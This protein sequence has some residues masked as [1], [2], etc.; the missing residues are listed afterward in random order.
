M[1]Y[2]KM[3]YISGVIIFVGVIVILVAISW[4]SGAN[5]FFTRDYS[6]YM[7][8]NEVSG[9]RD[10]SSVYMRGYHIGVTKGVGFEPN[11][12]VVRVEINKKFRVPKNSK[13]EIT[14][15]NLIGE[16]AISITPLPGESGGML[17]N[18]DTVNGENRD[19]MIV[20]QSVLSSL[21]TKIE[22]NDLDVKLRKVG[23]SLDLL[24]SALAK[25]NVRL[26]QFDVPEYSKELQTVGETGRRLQ[27]FLDATQPDIVQITSQGKTA[28]TKM[29][30][31]L[32]DFASL[33]QK[34]DSI[35]QKINAGQGSAG[36]LINN[37]AYV[38]DLA[39]TV[40]E[41]QLLITDIRKNP[42]KYFKIS[43]F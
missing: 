5:I 21:K 19:I 1:D 41:L 43:V 28:L 29:N 33:A 38:D 39:R 7:T 27:E 23:E 17:V 11:A 18:G 26:D 35:A 37:R 30:R 8:F 10:Q 42:G 9:L 32:D 20:A 34:L 16:K 2:G 40:G 12:V 6:V 36:E 13:F 22:G 31:A 14:S 15:L 24:H 25:L 4:L 3:S